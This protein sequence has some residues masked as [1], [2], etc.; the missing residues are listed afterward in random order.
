MRA[1][2]NRTSPSTSNPSRAN[3]P[4]STCIPWAISASPSLLRS[5]AP[6]RSRSPTMRAAGNRNS[7]ST[8]NPS[9]P[10][11]PPSTC[12]RSAISAYLPGLRSLAP[13]RSS[14]LPMCPPSNRTSPRKEHREK[15]TSLRV[16]ICSACRPAGSQQPTRRRTARSA[17]WS[18][19]AAASSS[20][21]PVSS[22]GNTTFTASRSMRPTIRTP[23]RCTARN[24]KG[25][26]PD[27]GGTGAS[28]MSN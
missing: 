23:P 20:Q 4:P 12:T 3:T 21:H 10:Y 26:S 18:S 8:S 19:G 7:P 27:S 24:T 22:S 5:L 15:I 16:L 2:D 6:V 17:V 28:P 13:V 14:T 9:R 1:P 11:T 25:L